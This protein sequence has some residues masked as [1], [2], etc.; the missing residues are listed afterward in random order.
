MEM[1]AGLVEAD[2][3]KKQRWQEASAAAESKK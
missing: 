3:E 2:A 1:D